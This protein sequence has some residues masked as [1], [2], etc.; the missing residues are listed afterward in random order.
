MTS[1]Q[2]SIKIFSDTQTFKK[3]TFFETFS[4]DATIPTKM[5]KETKNEEGMG[6]KKQEI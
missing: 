1:N 5:R 3:F 6:Y 2:R 4:L